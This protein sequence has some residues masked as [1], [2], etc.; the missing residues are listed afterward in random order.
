MCNMYIL[1]SE[2]FEDVDLITSYI[3]INYK[4]RKQPCFRI[5]TLTY[6]PFLL[7]C[8]PSYLNEKKSDLAW[9]QQ[10]LG[11]CGVEFWSRSR[12]SLMEHPCTTYVITYR[13]G[14]RKLT[15]FAHRRALA[16]KTWWGHHYMVGILCPP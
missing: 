11:T 14:V 12:T 9:R 3:S 1:H 13:R 16:F 6:S 7:A 5:S 15:I 2:L 4:P 8:L 10:R